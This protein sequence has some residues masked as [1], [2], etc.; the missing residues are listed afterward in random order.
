MKARVNLA[1]RRKYIAKAKTVVIQSFWIVFGLMFITFMAFT[2]FALYKT[3]SLRTQIE[4]VNER[5]V[6][7]SN[8]IRS[9]NEVVNEFV[10]SKGIL[11]QVEKINSGKFAYKRYMDEIVSIMPSSVVLRN[12]DFQNKGWVAVSAFVPDLTTVRDLESRITDK[13]IIDQTVFS[14]IFSEGLTRDKTGGYVIKFQFELK[15]NG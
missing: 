2:G 4:S 1:G 15:K 10:L 9:N 13:T 3:Y 6:I 11:D 5:S 14:S 8:E 12:V 7:I